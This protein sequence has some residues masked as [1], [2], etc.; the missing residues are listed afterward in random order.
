VGRGIPK[1]GGGRRPVRNSPKKVILE[2]CEDYSHFDDAAFLA[3]LADIL[4]K[5][6]TVKS[7]GPAG[8]RK[9]YTSIEVEMT[10][11]EIMRLLKVYKDGRL[12]DLNISTIMVAHFFY[13]NLPLAGGSKDYWIKH[14]FELLKSGLNNW[15]WPGRKTTQKKETH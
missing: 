9:G 8:T 2:V 1:G 13:D 3:N 14:Y 12:D 6:V 15:T 10:P 5:Q 7:I 4:L 11:V